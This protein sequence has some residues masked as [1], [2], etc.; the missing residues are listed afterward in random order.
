MRPSD[1]LS[2]LH[3]GPAVRAHRIVR[4]EVLRGESVRAGS[5]A[6]AGGHPCFLRDA[7]AGSPPWFLRV[8]LEGL[9]SPPPGPTRIVF[10]AGVSLRLGCAPPGPLTTSVWSVL[11]RCP[12]HSPAGLSQPR[13]G[14]AAGD[15]QAWW[16]R[17]SGC[18]AVCR[19]SERGLGEDR[20]FL[21]GG[22]DSWHDVRPKPALPPVALADGSTL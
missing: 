11:T 6:A 4:M 14:A 13:A 10:L 7:L 21:E 15:R 9:A 17:V 16:G 8:L 1:R 12:R 20:L 18:R 2:V 19:A 5:R 3:R 22:R